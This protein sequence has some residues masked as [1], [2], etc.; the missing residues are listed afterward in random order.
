MRENLISVG[1]NRSEEVFEMGSGVAKAVLEALSQGLEYHRGKTCLEPV[2]ATPLAFLTPQAISKLSLE[3]QWV[4][5]GIHMAP[6]QRTLC[7][8]PQTKGEYCF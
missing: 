3:S 5:Q 4:Q 6:A 1:K 2:R 7:F 8:V